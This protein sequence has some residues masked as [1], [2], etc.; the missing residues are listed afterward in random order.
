[1]KIEGDLSWFSLGKGW[2]EGAVFKGI[3]EKHCGFS[4]LKEIV[5]YIIPESLK[6]IS[7]VEIIYI[8]LSI[9]LNFLFNI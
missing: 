9:E 8:R 7:I 2:E 4:L 1:M 6:Q 5:D 3:S